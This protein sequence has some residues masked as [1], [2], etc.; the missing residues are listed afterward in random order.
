MDRDFVVQMRDQ[1][2]L[3]QRNCQQRWIF[4]KKG[5]NSRHHGNSAG[6]SNLKNPFGLEEPSEKI[7]V[8][9]EPVSITLPTKPSRLASA[10]SINL[11][12][13]A[14]PTVAE[15]SFWAWRPKSR[16][17][18][19]YKKLSKSP[20]EMPTDIICGLIQT[21]KVVESRA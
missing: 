12:V 7:L 6:K 8:N 3:S 21:M 19:D 4:L 9:G 15:T 14:Q 18:V 11:Y 13:G 2:G 5:R 20:E 10:W 16:L 1:Q 17:F